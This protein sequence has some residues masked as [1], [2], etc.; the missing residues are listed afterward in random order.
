MRKISGSLC[1]SFL[2]TPRVLFLLTRAATA[3]TASRDTCEGLMPSRSSSLRTSSS[4]RVVTCLEPVET[5]P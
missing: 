5:P 2:R 1:A 4:T 3:S